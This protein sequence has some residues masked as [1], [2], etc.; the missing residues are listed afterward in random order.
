M[1]KQRKLLVTIFEAKKDL[2]LGYGL[3]ALIFIDVI[4]KY[5][6]SI[7]NVFVEYALKFI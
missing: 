6:R 3:K 7:E 2:N 4:I 5:F 1:K